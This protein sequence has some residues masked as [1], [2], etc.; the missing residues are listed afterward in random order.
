MKYYINKLKY[1]EK[2]EGVDIFAEIYD[3]EKK[4]GWIE[5]AAYHAPA[6]YFDTPERRQE[7]IDSTGTSPED[8]GEWEAVIEGLIQDCERKFYGPEEYD[9]MLAEVLNG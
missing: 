7:F 8:G 5:Q 2:S 9:K 1:F 6:V 3:G 4:V